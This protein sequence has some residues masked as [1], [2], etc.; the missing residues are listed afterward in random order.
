MTSTLT[1]ILVT[2]TWH[3]LEKVGKSLFIKGCLRLAKPCE[4]LSDSYDVIDHKAK[5]K[6]ACLSVCCCCSRLMDQLKLQMNT[7][8]SY[9]HS[10]SSFEVAE[11]R[12]CLVPRVLKCHY[13]QDST[14]V[15][16]FSTSQW[17]TDLKSFCYCT[18]N[19][20]RQFHPRSAA[21][22]QLLVTRESI[23]L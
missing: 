1:T 4:V 7:C 19:N 18:R 3:E 16:T 12:F 17:Q 21:E 10:D 20:K 6:S 15:S 11:R 8:S 23:D 22:I 5:Y 9:Q 14:N 2:S 13:I